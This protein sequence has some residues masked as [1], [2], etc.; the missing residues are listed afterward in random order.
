MKKDLYFLVLLIILLI[1]MDYNF[2]DGF[3]IKTFQNGGNERETIFVERI[4][5][6]DTIE[7]SMGNVRL[8]G[9]NCPERGE[10]GYEQAKEYLNERIL[11]KSV[12]LQYG[13]EE[14]DKYE[15][16]LG[17]IFL[18]DLNVNLELVEKG[19]ANFYFPSGKDRYYSEFKSAWEKCISNGI[20]LCEKSDNPCGE[21][22]TLKEFDYS[23]EIVV[24]R[25][26]CDIDCDLDDWS[27]KDEGRKKLILNFSL[28]SL[29]DKE[30]MFE[31]VWTSTGDTLLLR[32]ENERLVLW[33]SY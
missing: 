16:I 22:I 3:L 24:L 12:A 6:G 17:Y 1:A 10:R 4:I 9:I 19:Y 27:I 15:R 25:N 5:D 2:I 31:D 26:I 11:N 30:I 23:N 18:E 29:E 20:N 7:S 8:L 33:K 13:N 14:K 21:C 32:D 28:G